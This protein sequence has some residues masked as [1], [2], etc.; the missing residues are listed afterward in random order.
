MKNQLNE[1]KQFQK[2]AG[3]LKESIS[4]G[5]YGSDVGV[6]ELYPL[7]SD[8]SSLI[9]T[10]SNL[11]TADKQA[12]FPI[13]QQIQGIVDAIVD[14]EDDDNHRN[15]DDYGSDNPDDDYGPV[16]DYGKMKKADNDAYYGLKED[17]VSMGKSNNPE[18]DKRV[19][20]F[21]KKI[22]K[23][24]NYPVSQAVTFVQDRIKSL[25]KL[26]AIKNQDTK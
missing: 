9:S 11:S 12:M 23:E 22:A 1:V 20:G 25:Q 14:E 3:L 15:D 21:L 26:G 18:G 13:L 19:L 16:T 7:I 6:Q 4:E 8:L 5:S 10:N 17:S 2:I 24:F